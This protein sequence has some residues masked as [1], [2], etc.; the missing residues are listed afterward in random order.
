MTSICQTDHAWPQVTIA[1]FLAVYH[2]G[3]DSKQEYLCAR[4]L[5][6][7]CDIAVDMYGIE[8]IEKMNENK[9]R[10][11]SNTNA[12]QDALHERRLSRRE[13][14]QGS[15][16]RVSTPPRGDARLIRAYH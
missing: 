9:V 12:D 1:Y 4:A 7:D 3:F 11:S 6:C 15:K 14:A 8:T 2:V 16:T 5:N 10:A 13:L